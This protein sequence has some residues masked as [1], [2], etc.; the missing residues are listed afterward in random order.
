M[1]KKVEKKTELKKFILEKMFKLE[2]ISQT[3]F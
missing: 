3:K 1:E 2:K